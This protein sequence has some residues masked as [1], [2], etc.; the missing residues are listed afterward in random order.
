MHLFSGRLVLPNSNQNSMG[1]ALR[2]L[3]SARVRDMRETHFPFT[4]SIVMRVDESFPNYH[5]GSLH[6]RDGLVSDFQLQ[7]VHRVIGN[8][9]RDDHTMSDVDAHMRRGLPLLDGDYVPLQLIASTQL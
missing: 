1:F 9:R 2:C 7:L 8:R 6:D 5:I 4:D 3:M